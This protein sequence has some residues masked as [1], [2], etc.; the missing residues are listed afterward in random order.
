MA[1][2]RDR[3]RGTRIRAVV[4]AVVVF[5]SAFGLKLSAEQTAAIYGLTE[6]LL[7]LAVERP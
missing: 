7:Q 1:A 3:S 5:G 4:R 6:S 2:I